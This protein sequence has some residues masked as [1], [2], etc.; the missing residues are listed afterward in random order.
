[1]NQP[2]GEDEPVAHPASLPKLA[3]GSQGAAVVTL[4]KLLNS[5][6]KTRGASAIGAD[7]QFGPETE[8][9]LLSFQREHGLETTGVVDELTWAQLETP[10]S[11]PA[12][13]PA[14]P[15]PTVT[16]TIGIDAVLTGRIDGS[17]V[18]PAP[19]AQP[20]V[21]TAAHAPMS[22]SASALDTLARL[23]ESEAGVCSDTGKV[24]VGAVVLNR[25]RAGYANGTVQGVVS[26]SGQFDGYDD[27]TYRGTPSQASRNAATRAAAGEDPSNN[28]LYYYNPYLA[29]PAWAKTMKQTARIG[30]NDTNTHVFYRP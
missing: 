11:A 3:E 6:R 4:Q 21:S 15:T 12:Q 24:A 22:L 17:K 23:I 10:A 27:A 7:G 16:T 19:T 14:S 18:A 13:P 1:M 5:D 9:A 2:L 8:T 28:A 25:V 26:E 30:T 29:N 20:V